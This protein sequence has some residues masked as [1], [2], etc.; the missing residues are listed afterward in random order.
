LATPEGF[1][2]DPRLVWE[3]YQDRQRC[4]KKASPNPAHHA[5]V[6]MEDRYPSFDLITQ[7]IDGIHRR[8]GSRNVIELH[9]NIWRVRCT[10]DGTVFGIDDPVDEIPPLCECG[11][12]LRPDV[13]WFGEQLPADAVS[14]ASEAVAGCDV[15]LVIGTSAVVYPAA[16]LPMIAKNSGAFVIELNTE[17]TD[18]TSYADASLIGPAGT[19]LPEIWHRVK[20][21]ESF[22]K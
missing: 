22:I 2:E 10:R 8:A 9:G 19:I 6:E 16:A 15:M 14:R 13:V 21:P 20:H 5:L 12:I 1:R 18:V 17:K 4:I 7:N 3:W 11:S